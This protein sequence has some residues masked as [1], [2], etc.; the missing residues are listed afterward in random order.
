MIQKSKWYLTHWNQP[1]SDAWKNQRIMFSV[2]ENQP[3]ETKQDAMR[4]CEEESSDA[5]PISGRKI[6]L[7]SS[8]L[9]TVDVR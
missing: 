9:Y 2:R 4:F 5:K 6:L 1:D 8:H 3:F 7:L